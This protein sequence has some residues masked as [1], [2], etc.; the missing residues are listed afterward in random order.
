MISVRISK[1]GYYG[2]SPEAVLKSRVD[3]VLAIA[4]YE[5]FTADYEDEFYELNK[6]R[7]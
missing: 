1:A 6:R 7:D 5:K 3:H 4:D 2:G